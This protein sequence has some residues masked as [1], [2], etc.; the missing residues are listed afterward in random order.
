MN[1]HRRMTDGKTPTARPLWTSTLSQSHVL[2]VLVV[3]GLLGTASALQAATVQWN[4][5]PES[6]IAGYKLS[7]GTQTGVYTTSIDTGNVTTWN[8]TLTPGT[9]YF[10]VLQA[11][12]TGGLYSAYSA[13]VI[14]DAPPAPTLTLTS[15]SP[16]SGPVATVVTISGSNFGASQGSSTVT[17]NGTAASPTSWSATSIGVPVPA[18]A[19]TGNVVV[20]VAGV[21]SNPL[22]YTVTVPP[23]L[24]SL[25]PSSG[26]VATAVTIAG[27]N[28]G[29]TQGTSSV[30]FSGIAAT[31]TSWSATRIVVSIPAGATSGNVVVT[32]GGLA[33]PA[34]PFLINPGVP[35]GFRLVPR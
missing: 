29:S 10:F 25:S 8:V 14:Y 35:A 9:R 31:P 2:C 30:T 13:E 17:F 22:T 26:P 16:S 3:A 34:V 33:S 6:D 11:Y 4:P 28:F 23:T 27:S 19:T 7:Y 32:V 20:T 5:N 15:L 24:T 18:G 1:Q 12:N 21:A